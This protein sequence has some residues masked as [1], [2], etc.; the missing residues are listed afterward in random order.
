VAWDSFTRSVDEAERLAQPESFDHLHLL[1]ESYDQVRRYAPA[2][3]ETFDFRAARLAP[4]PELAPCSLPRIA[5]AI[6]ESLKKKVLAAMANVA[7]SDGELTAEQFRLLRRVGRSF[8]IPPLETREIVEKPLGLEGVVVL[9]K[10]AGP[11]EKIPARA[12]PFALDALRIKALSKETR[13]IITLL[14]EIMADPIEDEPSNE[15]VPLQ[16][17]EWLALLECRY[18]PPLLALLSSNQICRADF[19]T[20]ATRHHLVPLYTLMSGACMSK[21]LY[22]RILRRVLGSRNGAVDGIAPIA[23]LY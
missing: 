6:P 11:G 16:A 22:I 8:E 7:C 21:W 20:L 14:S 5:K 3:P 2:L 12:A 23:F 13:E 19:N 17:P 18:H 10:N 4:D 15:R 1:T 9:R